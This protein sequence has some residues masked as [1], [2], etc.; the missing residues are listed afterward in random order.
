[1]WIKAQIHKRGLLSLMMIQA[2]ARNLF[3]DLKGKYPKGVQAFA[4]SSSW[5][6]WFK[7]C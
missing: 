5:F 7:E 4:A 1:M 3:E 6:S 2:K